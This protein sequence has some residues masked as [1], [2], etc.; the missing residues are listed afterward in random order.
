MNKR[1]IMSIVLLFFLS[2]TCLADRVLDRTEILQLLVQLTAQ[3]KEAWITAGSIQS[4]HEQF[5]AANI[6]DENQI[7]TQILDSISEYQSNTDK[8]ERTE[9]LQKLK[10]DAIP[11]NTRYKIS[12]EYTMSASESVTYDGQRYYWEINI[13]SRNDS[14][15]PDKYLDGNYMT[16]QFNMDINVRKIYAW[17]GDNYIKYSPLAQHSYVDTVGQLPHN[18]NGPLKA[19]LIPWGYGYYSYDNLAAL[20]SEA[21]ESIIDGAAQIYLTFTNNDGSQISVVLDTNK[22]YAVMSCS[23]IGKSNS[24]ISKQYADYQNM[25][26]NWVPTSILMEKHDAQT[27]RLLARDMWTFDNVDTTVPASDAFIVNYQEDTLIEYVSP[28]NGRP[29]VYRY[30]SLIDTDEILIEK[31]VYDIKKGTQPQNCATAAMKYAIQQM[32][33]TVEDSQLAEL[34]TE[35]DNGTNMYD[36]KLF[37]QN[38][39]LNCR[40]IQTDLD[41]IRYMEDCQIVLYL[42]SRKH[43]V[44]LN[45]IDDYVRFVDI[46]STKFFDRVDTNFFNMEWPSAIALV[47]SKNPIQ[48]NFQEVAD[49]ELANIIGASG[50]TCTRV[51]QLYSTDFCDYI[52]EE[53]LGV[54]TTYWPRYGC[55][56]AESGSC[57]YDWFPR[58]SS[59]PCINDV[60]NPFSCDITGDWADVW[61]RACD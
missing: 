46:A 38:L 56:S 3:Q 19:G 26:G 5:R 20:D 42:P 30:S 35:P 31:L 8:I 36:M 50:Y 12:N 11:F 37:A 47:L 61:M 29:L 2:F 32:G 21:T 54:Y 53:C 48:G 1:F 7:N 25:G 27:Q 44:V 59:S 18:V 16:D 4:T 52:A 40:V 22:E 60:Y 34:I 24:V 15:K 49:A 39:G 23:I 45:S 10:L 17:D 51:L 14:V 55:E 43:F 9:H 58:Y 57:S 41:T 6:I 13:Q 28:F 33:M